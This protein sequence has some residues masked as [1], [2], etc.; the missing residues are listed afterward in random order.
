MTCLLI[1]ERKGE[2]ER[3]REVGRDRQEEGTEKKME[4]ERY[5]DQLPPICTWTEVQTNDLDTFP[6]WGSNHKP[7]G[8]WDNA[9]TTGNI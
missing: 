7:L 8:A 1:L 5:T 9:P 6:D 4:R 3:E 2:R